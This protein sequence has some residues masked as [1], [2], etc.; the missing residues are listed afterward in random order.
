[1]ETIKLL[2]NNSYYNIAPWKTMEF[3]TTPLQFVW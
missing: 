3:L 2:K 1:M